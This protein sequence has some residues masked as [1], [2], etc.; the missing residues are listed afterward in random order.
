MIH[1]TMNPTFKR[2]SFL[3]GLDFSRRKSSVTY[4]DLL[5][6]KVVQFQRRL[7]DTKVFSFDIHHNKNL[8]FF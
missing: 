2:P 4:N 3:K 7:I 6:D 5:P 1:S 8:R